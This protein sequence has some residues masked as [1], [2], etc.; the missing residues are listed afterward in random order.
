[1]ESTLEEPTAF[2]ATMTSRVEKLNPIKRFY[3]TVECRRNGD[4]QRKLIT[5]EMRNKVQNMVKGNNLFKVRIN[6]SENLVIKIFSAIFMHD[7]TGTT[8]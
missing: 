1:M 7:G 3:L 2:L 5:L 4:R 8:P 6:I